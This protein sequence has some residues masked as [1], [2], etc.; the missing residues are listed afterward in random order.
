MLTHWGYGKAEDRMDPL[1]GYGDASFVH[2]WVLSD[3][4]SPLREVP[5]FYNWYWPVSDR[6]DEACPCYSGAAKS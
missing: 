3:A 2:G 5:Y 4:L 6:V 1:V